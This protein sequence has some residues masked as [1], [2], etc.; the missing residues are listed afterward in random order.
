METKIMSITHRAPGGPFRIGVWCDYHGTLTPYG[1]IGVFVYNL[2]EGILELDE[3]VRIVMLIRAGEEQVASELQ[4]RARGRLE[5]IPQIPR[6][7]ILERLLLQTMLGVDRARSLREQLRCAVASRSL[8]IRQRLLTIF[9]EVSKR[10][11]QRN[12]A[13]WAMG[14][15]LVL[16]LPMIFLLAWPCYGVAQLAKALVKTTE[17]P[18]RLFGAFLRKLQKQVQD[19]LR[20]IAPM[21]AAQEAHCDVWVIPWVAFADP[22]PFPSVLFVHDLITSHFPEL[23]SP[24]FVSFINRVAPARAAEATLVA[25]LSNFIRDKDLLG[26]LGLPPA[27]I[28]VVR[29]AAPRDFPTLSR[30]E[31]Q[32]LKPA[33]LKRP[34]IFLPAGIRPAKNHQALIEALRILR[35][36]YG[37]EEW[38]LVFTGEQPGQLGEK[39]QNL[40]T[41]YRLLDRVHVLGKVDRV[42]LAALYKCA[43]ATIMPTFYEEQSF[44]VYEALHWECPVACSDIPSLRELCA[45]MGEAMLYFDPRYAEELARTILKIRENRDKIRIQQQAAGR[46]LLERTWKEVAREWLVV[47]REAAEIS[48]G[49][50]ASVASEKQAA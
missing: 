5:L 32:S 13:T 11:R 25:C 26:V 22:L 40:V 24:E 14:A 48:R 45:A 6:P 49:K 20:V 31:A 46:A 18:L 4:K 30:E 7:T 29:A 8:A 28:H 34:Y 50:P 27:K 12:W 37:K 3:A 36:E 21:Q 39:L 41:Q 10:A 9:K 35:D 43:W 42:T 44:P 17:F 33:H 1:G 16:G 19:R 47:F 38:D 2:L 23:F 15:S